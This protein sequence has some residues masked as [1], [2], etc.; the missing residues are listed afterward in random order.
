VQ[1]AAHIEDRRVVRVARHAALGHAHRGLVCADRTEH[2]HAAGDHRDRRLFGEPR[3]GEAL[4]QRGKFI[5]ETQALGQC[6]DQRRIARTLRPCG[7]DGFMRLHMPPLR[8]QHT[9][10]PDQRRHV[11]PVAGKRASIGALGCVPLLAIHRLFR[12]HPQLM[13]CHDITA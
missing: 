13:S 1:V 7:H 3:I 10:K 6:V 8:A 2:D 12:F 5:E 4:F 9:G 11:R